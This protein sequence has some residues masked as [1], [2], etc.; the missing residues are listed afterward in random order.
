V[1]AADLAALA[2]ALDGHVVI[3]LVGYEALRG[4][5]GIEYVGF[6]W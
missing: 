5:V 6:C 4:L 3:D 2:A 1:G